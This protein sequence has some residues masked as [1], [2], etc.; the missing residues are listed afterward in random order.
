M[1]ERKKNQIVFLFSS[2]GSFK[3]RRSETK[4]YGGNAIDLSLIESKYYLMKEIL[5]RCQEF[6]PL[7]FFGKF[8]RFDTRDNRRNFEKIKI[9]KK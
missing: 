5:I 9:E 1:Y 2:F 4:N 8:I 3:N 6:W 7:Q